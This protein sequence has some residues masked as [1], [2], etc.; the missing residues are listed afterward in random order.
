VGTFLPLLAVRR[1]LWP[2][3]VQRVT[4]AAAVG[5]VGKGH[6]GVAPSGDGEKPTCSAR[7]VSLGTGSLDHDGPSCLSFCQPS[8]SGGKGGRSRWVSDKE[9][10]TR[11]QCGQLAYAVHDLGRSWATI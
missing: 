1:G 6:Q 8:T 9:A 2:L 5:G 11:N 3:G 7:V 10:E 4:V